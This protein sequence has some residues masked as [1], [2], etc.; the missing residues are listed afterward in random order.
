VLEMRL[1]TL[2]SVVLDSGGRYFTGARLPDGSTLKDI[3]TGRLVVAP[4][5][6]GEQIVMLPDVPQTR[7]PLVA[8]DLRSTRFAQRR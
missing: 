2:P 4:A 1:G 6:G 8:P 3:S 5:Q 7:E